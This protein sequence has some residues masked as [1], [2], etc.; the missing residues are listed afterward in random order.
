[1]II[2]LSLIFLVS[3]TK[4]SRKLKKVVK[5]IKLLG[6]CQGKIVPFRLTASKTF[7][8]TKPCLGGATMTLG[9]GGTEKDLEKGA[10]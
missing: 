7:E 8:T 10:M 9:G 2:R 5:L 6:I 4:V 3:L 1:M